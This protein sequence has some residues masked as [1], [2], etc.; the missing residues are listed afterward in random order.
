MNEYIFGG[1]RSNLSLS[2]SA[3][4][5]VIGVCDDE[6][7][8]HVFIEK[9]LENY[10]I[11]KKFKVSVVHFLSASELLNNDK[12]IDL[13][14]LDI[15][16]PEMDGIEAGHILRNRNVEYKIIM[17]TGREDRFREAFEIEAYRFVTK[18]IDDEKL[19]KA[20]DDV[21]NTIKLKQKVLVFRDGVQYSIPQKEI[22]Y[23][24]AN[25]SSTLVFTMNVEFRSE[26][27]LS[28][29]ATILDQRTFFRC[30]KSFIVN[31]GKIDKIQDSYITMINGDRVAI[32]RRLRKSFVNTYMIYDTKWR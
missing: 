3:E 9:A 14:L 16:M 24:E 29:W 28:F 22:L 18:P 6:N 2:Q 25:R 23:V 10:A 1:D 5:I 31:M 11:E 19:F 15:D 30:H 17:L 27:S 4:Q 8:V 26:Q 12:D 13:L 7:Y 21:R 32:S 20:I